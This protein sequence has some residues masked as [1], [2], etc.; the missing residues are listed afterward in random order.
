LANAI[1]NPA[2]VG[3]ASAALGIFFPAP[4]VV[5]FLFG[6]DFFR[7]QRPPVFIKI[8]LDILTGIFETVTD[9]VF[10]FLS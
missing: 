9:I 1:H 4:A 8:I 2:D 3:Q 10:H 5:E 7:D 6:L